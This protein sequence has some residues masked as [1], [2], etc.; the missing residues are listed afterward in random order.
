MEYVTTNPYLGIT[1]SDDLKW[2]SHS[3]AI[4]KKANSILGFLRRNICRCL[5][6]S[7][8]TAYIALV[9]AVLEYGAI[10]LDPYHRGDID[11]LEKIQHRAARF[12]IGDYR[13]RHPG[14]VTTMIT[15]LNLDT[16]EHRRRD[17]R[18]TFI[19]RTI[20]GSIPALPTET[21]FQPQKKNK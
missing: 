12:V 3:S 20:K 16:L 10:V 7:K 14:S 15:N 5:L 21:L 11:K 19:Y 4:N 2:H 17:Q 8:R 6:N 18:L 9:R 1:L 13:S